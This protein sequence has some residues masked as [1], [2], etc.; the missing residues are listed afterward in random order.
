M[1]DVRIKVIY[2]PLA[3][4]ATTKETPTLMQTDDECMWKTFQREGDESIDD[5]DDEEA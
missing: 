4:S 1:A 5:A 3:S 2:E